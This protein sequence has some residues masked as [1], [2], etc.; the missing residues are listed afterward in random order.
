MG[1]SYI[2]IVLD[3]WLKDCFSPFYT[4]DCGGFQPVGVSGVAPDIPK[5]PGSWTWRDGS[6]ESEK[7][8]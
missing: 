5:Y 8:V 1:T 7:I 6:V 2:C 3:C 4:G